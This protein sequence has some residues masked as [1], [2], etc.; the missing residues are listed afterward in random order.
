MKGKNWPWTLFGFFQVFQLGALNE[1]RLTEEIGDFLACN[2]NRH[3]NVVSLRG[4]KGWSENIFK[5]LAKVETIG[6]SLGEIGD[7]DQYK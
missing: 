7:C 2:F 6:V 3:V 5:H 4:S 1:T